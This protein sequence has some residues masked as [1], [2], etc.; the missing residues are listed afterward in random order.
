MFRNPIPRGFPRSNSFLIFL[1]EGTLTVDFKT[2]CV[3]M[4]EGECK[5][6]GL[7]VKSVCRFFLLVCR[8]RVFL[9]LPSGKNED[10][11]PHKVGSQD[12]KDGGPMTP[13][14]YGSWAEQNP[15]CLALVHESQTLRTVQLCWVR[16]V[17]A[18]G[19]A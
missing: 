6:P 18:G 5:E 10:T 2:E 9:G 11:V 13:V 12:A 16:V 3:P 15:E 1:R 7:N 19:D 8:L 4:R 14:T 17:S